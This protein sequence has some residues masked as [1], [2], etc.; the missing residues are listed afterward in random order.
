YLQH[1]L[2]SARSVSNNQLICI[3]LTFMSYKFFKGV[4]GEQAEKS[5]RASEFVARKVM[6]GL[7]QSV[8]SGLLADTL[9]MAGKGQEAESMRQV[10]R[11]IA[12]SLPEGVIKWKD[13]QGTC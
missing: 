13:K 10:G 2:Q 7:W 3:A 1:A 4:V 5:A 12:R 11:E 8:S 6:D 9:D